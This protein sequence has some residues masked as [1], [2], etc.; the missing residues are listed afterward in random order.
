MNE[1]H[2]TVAPRCL[3]DAVEGLTGD[4]T[5]L[6]RRDYGGTVADPNA[7]LKPVELEVG[8]LWWRGSWPGATRWATSLRSSKSAFGDRVLEAWEILD[9]AVRR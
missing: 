3:D 6:W 5:A 1:S 9:P 8:G 4:Q 7:A 2:R